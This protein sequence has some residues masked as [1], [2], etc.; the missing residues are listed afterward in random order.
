MDLSSFSLAVPSLSVHLK[1]NRVT[2]HKNPV[3]LAILSVSKRITPS[4]VTVTIDEHSDQVQVK[5]VPLNGFTLQ[6]PTVNLLANDILLSSFF[7]KCITFAFASLSTHKF[8]IFIWQLLI[9]AATKKSVLL[10][11]FNRSY[12]ACHVT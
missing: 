12:P 4:K 11:F 9:A 1:H 7:A 2:I 5:S 6:F 8:S 3:Q 10:T